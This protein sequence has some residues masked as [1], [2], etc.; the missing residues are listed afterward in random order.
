METSS[1][2]KLSAAQITGWIIW[3]IV[4]VILIGIGFIAYFFG[5]ADTSSPMFWIVMAIFGVLYLVQQIIAGVA[6]NRLH[7]NNNYVWPI[8]L[9]VLS[10]LGSFIYIIPGVWALIINNPSRNRSS[11]SN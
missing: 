3:W 8:V 7:T 4:T 1:K 6:I 2:H 10:L 9:I 11:N 5:D